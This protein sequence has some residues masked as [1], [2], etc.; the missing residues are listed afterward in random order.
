[1]RSERDVE[2][3]GSG[4]DVDWKVGFKMERYND[5]MLISRLGGC[6]FE[7]C[8]AKG[9]CWRDGDKLAGLVGW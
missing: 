9:R 8:D 2:V 7:I 6:C 3:V 4:F 5:V 1:M